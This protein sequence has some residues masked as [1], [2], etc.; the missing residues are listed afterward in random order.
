MSTQMRCSAAT[1]WR[2][3]ECVVV[4][5]V[6]VVAAAAAVS[7]M[8]VVVRVTDAFCLLGVCFVCACTGGERAASVDHQRLQCGRLH[9]CA[10]NVVGTQ[11]PSWRAH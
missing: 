6:V 8:G 9:V 1:A 7:A 2:K 10:A 11:E 5:V 3:Q 4:V